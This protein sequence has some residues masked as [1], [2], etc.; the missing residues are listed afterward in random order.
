MQTSQ[1]LDKL[2]TLEIIDNSYFANEQA[3]INNIKNILNK[4][5]AT[6]NISAAQQYAKILIERLRNNSSKGNIVQNLMQEFNLSSDEGVALMCLAEALLRIPDVS[7]RNALIKDKLTSANIKWESHLDNKHDLFIHAAIWGLV[8]SKKILH[9]NLHAI[10]SNIISK[11]GEPIIHKSVQVAMHMMGEQFVVGQNIAEAIKY[12][13]KSINSNFLYSYDMLGEAALTNNCAIEYLKSYEQAIHAIGKNCKEDNNIYTNNGISIKISAL[14]PN[15]NHTKEQILIDELYP[16]LL[17]LADLACQYNIGLNIDAEEAERLNISL[18][19]FKKLCSEKK[20]QNWNGLG[21]VVQ[22]YSKRAYASIQYL[23]N[24]AQEYKR[25]IMLRLVKGAYWDSEIKLAQ[26][27]GMP[28]YPVYTVKQHTDCSYLACVLLMLDNP[29]H[30]YPQFASHNALSIATVL[31][32][33]KDKNYTQNYEF[34]CLHGM[35]EDIYR[36]VQQDNPDLNCRIYAPVGSHT[37]LLPY[38]VRRLLE[39]GANSSF[40]NQISNPNISIDQ[41][42][43]CP[44]NA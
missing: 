31:Q 1:I 23:V 10:L 17:H 32:Y 18:I 5:N 40:V 35:G 30:V 8:I 20:L 11:C 22:A 41:L 19:L 13:Q 39:N 16:R 25:K 29:E 43:A 9:N 21:F 27:Q 37:T 12:S 4:H 38:L 15:Y 3:S 6:K 2:I 14:H 26:S 33:I 34:Q 36:L 24:L 7:T 44:I 28:E 42:I